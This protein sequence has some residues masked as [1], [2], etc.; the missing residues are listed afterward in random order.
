[1]LPQKTSSPEGQAKLKEVL[2]EMDFLVSCVLI[3]YIQPLSTNKYTYIHSSL[4]DIQL[5]KLD[6]IA[7]VA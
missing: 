7:L 2:I 3:I 6:K 5:F 4:W 1:M